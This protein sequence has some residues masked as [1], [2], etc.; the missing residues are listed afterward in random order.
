MPAFSGTLNANEI[1]SS[2]FNM[3]IS[4]QINADNIKEGFSSLV[5][6]ARVDGGL[7]GDTKLYYDTDVLKSHAW[8]GDTEASNLL[9]LDRPADPECQA[10]YLNTFRQIRVT[11]DYYLSKRAWKDEGAFSQFNSVTLGWLRDTKKVYDLTTY[12][13]FMGVHVSPVQADKNVTLSTITAPVTTADEEAYN[14]L[15][16]QKIGEAIAN[17]VIDMRDVSRDFN[18]YNHLKSYD[19]DEIKIIFNSKFLNE[20][21]YL[22]LPTI[23]H[24][25]GVVAKIDQDTLPARYF[26]DVLTAS[27]TVGATDDIR[28]MYEQEITVSGT[29]YHLFAGDKFPVG[30]VVASGDGYEVNPNIVAKVVTELPPYMS[31]FEVGT[32]F[33]N[34]RSLTE[35]HYLTFGHNELEHRYDK[36]F[37]RIM[38]N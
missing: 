20:L 22:D 5:N 15:R 37:V 35:N 25:E 14:R 29:P 7:Y 34:A 23:F 4:Q 26:G 1:F 3:I 13:T 19:E 31:A 16:A 12:N 9:A 33:F 28:A 10:I 24:K 17:M 11:V 6:R 36:P 21:K 8:G 38:E 32:S 27:K 2:L 18:D 30:A